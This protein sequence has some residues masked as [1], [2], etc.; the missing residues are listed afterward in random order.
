[1]IDLI[2]RLGAAPEGVITEISEADEMYR[3]DRLD[4]YFQMGQS[5]LR[6]IRLAMLAADKREVRNLLDFPCGH[7]RVLRNAQGGVSPGPSH[8][9]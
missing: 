5:A 9:R 4:W 3:P 7:G 6:C 2:E 1:M 8:R